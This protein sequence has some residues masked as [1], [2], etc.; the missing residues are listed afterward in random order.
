MRVVFKADPMQTNRLI[1]I[2]GE[3]KLA[4]INWSRLG[5]VYLIKGDVNALFEPLVEGDSRVTITIVDVAT[6]K[7]LPT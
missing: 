3:G 1:A 2:N 6:H 4:L 5:E 7:R